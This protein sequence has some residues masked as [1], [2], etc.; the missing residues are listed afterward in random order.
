MSR[1]LFLRR[2]S[3]AVLGKIEGLYRAAG[4]WLR[5]DTRKALARMVAGSHCFLVVE[6]D[7][8]LVAMGRAI[9]DRAN[10]AYIQDLF[11]VPS[12]RGRGLAS[13]VVRRLVR[14]LRADGLRWIGLVA[15]DGTRPLY[16]KLGFRRMP[17]SDPMLCER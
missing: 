13:A 16:E 10:D 12:H 6:E 2:P 3:P 11:V 1:V 8:R 5:G 17:D 4:W 15:A 7:G 14:R 9:S